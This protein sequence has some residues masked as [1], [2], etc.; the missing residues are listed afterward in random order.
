MK[1]YGALTIYLATGGKNNLWAF[2]SR[3]RRQG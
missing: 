3:M 1:T 2:S